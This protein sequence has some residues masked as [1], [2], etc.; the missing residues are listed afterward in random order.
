MTGVGF[1][2]FSA[3]DFPT[4]ELEVR[5]GTFSFD[6]DD[7][8]SFSDASFFFANGKLLGINFIVDIEI[9][10]PD[11]INIVNFLLSFDLSVDGFTSFPVFTFFDPE[12]RDVSGAF[13]IP[14]PGTL[15]LIGAGLAGLGLLR[16][17]R[18]C[19]RAA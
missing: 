11:I 8:R 15:A 12:G 7:Q 6:Q 10:T 18:N 1:E 3:D 9:P 5:I 14:E 19:V 4:L 2:T 17:R 16:R 13:V